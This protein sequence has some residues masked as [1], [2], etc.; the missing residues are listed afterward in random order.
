MDS[1]T[2]RSVHSPVLPSYKFCCRCKFEGEV[3]E[4]TCQ[5]C[6]NPLHA[7][8]MIRVLGGMM[9]FLSLILI[10]GM[11][12]IIYSIDLSI[13]NSGKPGSTTKWTA[14]PEQ[15]WLMFGV[16]YT[17]L[18]IGVATFIAG[19]WHLVIGRRNLVLFWLIFGLTA[20]LF[21]LSRFLP[22]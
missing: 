13:I 8:Q 21:I 22:E 17:V 2:E 1:L 10:V 4:N 14:P 7:R 16:L 9:L 18:A 19:L 12:Y 15:I 6:G 5:K 20:A 3:A 11:A